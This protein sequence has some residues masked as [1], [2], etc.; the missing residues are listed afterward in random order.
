LDSNVSAKRNTDICEPQGGCSSPLEILVPTYQ[1]TGARIHSRSRFYPEDSKFLKTVVPVKLQGVTTQ[2]KSH[3]F[4]E[5][6][7]CT[8][9]TPRNVGTHV[10]NYG[11]S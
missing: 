11:V 2:D 1:I 9:Y 4:Y 7:D 8:L 10:S 5:E 6:G 3:S